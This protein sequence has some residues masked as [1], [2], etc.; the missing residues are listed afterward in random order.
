VAL[1]LRRVRDSRN[2]SVRRGPHLALSAVSV[3]AVLAGA[4]IVAT[5]GFP[6]RP[7]AASSDPSTFSIV[8]YDSITGELGVAVQSKYFSVGRTVP[9]AKAGVGAVATQANVNASYGPRALVLLASKNSPQD[10]LRTFAAA[11]SSW[12]GRQLGIVD[13]QGRVAS[14]TGPKCNTW[15]GGQTGTARGATF[16]CQGNILAGPA[17]VSEMARAFTVANGELAERLVAAIEAGQKAG[18]DK[19][20]QQSAALIVVR[21]STA[22][23]EYAER[24]VDLR[25]E[26]DTSAVAELR[27]VWTIH[28]GFHG[29][30]AHMDMAD[31][32]DAAG[33]KSLA[34]LERERVHQT[35]VS[36]L[37]RNETDADMLNGLAWSV[38]V[39][40]VELPDALRAAQRAA[41]LKPNST[42]IL[43]TLAEVHFRMNDREKALEVGKRALAL[44]PENPYLKAQVEKFK[45]KPKAPG[46]K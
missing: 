36:A 29:A 9:W 5:V 30:G 1:A 42:D 22:H 27:R 33:K 32:Y 39:H 41:E 8:A 24:F 31:E 46:A 26:D 40:D 7:A 11:D 16:A 23:P 10:I 13:A 12:D 44:D 37:Q 25:V 21:P 4:A 38:A 18:G 14:W 20:G 34:R 15:A 6:A 17:V 3:G 28:Q 35:L 2:A 45:A 19:R 43:D